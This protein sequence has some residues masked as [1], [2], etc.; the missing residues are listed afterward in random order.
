MGLREEIANKLSENGS[1][2]PVELAKEFGVKEYEILQNLPEEIAKAVDAN[3]FDEIIQEVRDWGELLFVKTT[4]SFIIEFKTKV[5]N[6]KHMKGYYNF[7]MKDS[8]MGGHLKADDIEKIIFV[9]KKFMGLL[10]HS[11]EFYRADGE[12]IFKLFLSRNE[13]R[14]ILPEQL[15]AFKKMKARF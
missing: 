15:E 7:D 6:G 12:V 5:A 11:I 13:K 4:P 14:E 8:P 9:S 2:T 3:R 1:L 10:S